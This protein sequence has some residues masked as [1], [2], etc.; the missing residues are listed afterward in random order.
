VSSIVYFPGYITKIFPEQLELYLAKNVAYA[1][2]FYYGFNF[3]GWIIIGAI[4]G[5]LYGRCREGNFK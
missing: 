2:L 5:Y 4:V 1:I 3:V